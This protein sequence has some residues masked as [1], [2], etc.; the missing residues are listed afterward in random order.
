L[1]WEGSFR[2]VS[3]VPGNFR[4]G[5]I[6][7]LFSH[8]SVLVSFFVGDY[9]ESYLSRAIGSYQQQEIIVPALDVEKMFYHVR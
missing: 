4:F 9:V 1:K 6:L 2:E 8:V 7:F 3:L 5:P